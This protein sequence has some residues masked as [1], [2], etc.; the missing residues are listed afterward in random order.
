MRVF[1]MRSVVTL[2]AGAFTAAALTGCTP[3]SL[4]TDWV[5]TG[6]SVVVYLSWT[7][8][9]GDLSGN[10]QWAQIDDHNAVQSGSD[11]FTGTVAD[12]KVTLRMSSGGV[13]T[14]S[15]SSDSLRLSGTS[16]GVSQ[17]WSFKPGAADQFHTATAALQQ[18]ADSD[19][20]QA[21]D[22]AAQS[23]Y[24]T[25][26][27]SLPTVVEDSQTSLDTEQAALAAA[28]Q[29]VAR[30]QQLAAQAIATGCYSSEAAK[31]ASSAFYDNAAA[32]Q[33]LDQAISS[34]RPHSSDL[35]KALTPIT[36]PTGHVNQTV[37]ADKVTAATSLLDRINSAVDG[38]S[39]TATAGHNTLNDVQDK[40]DQLPYC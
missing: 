37:P 17:D 34:L 18:T 21:A 4:P 29:A 39:A 24:D 12:G 36:A 19:R 38:D 13:F 23:D 8:K 10:E 22:A 31:A 1:A 32:V 14:G 25:A 2:I 33:D 20:Q 28:N 26:A 40:V 16:N 9:D 7:A 5:G 35:S 30:Q 3:T 6:A 15:I 11:P 27:T